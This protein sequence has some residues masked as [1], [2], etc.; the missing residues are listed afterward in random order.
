[1][2]GYPWLH[3]VRGDLLM[4]LGRD[5]EARQ[6]FMDAAALTDNAREREQ[7]LARAGR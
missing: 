6:A 1:L 4:K 5:A 3:A 7:L 2:S